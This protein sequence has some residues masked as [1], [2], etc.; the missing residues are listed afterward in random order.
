MGRS[1]IGGSLGPYL[2]IVPDWWLA[3]AAVDFKF[4][5]GQY[6]NGADGADVTTLLSISRA[7]VAY[8]QTVAGAL[9]SFATNTLRITDKGLLVEGSRENVNQRSQALAD[10]NQL[11]GTATNNQTAAPDGTTTA[12]KYADDTSNGRHLFG[13]NSL[14]GGDLANGTT[15]VLSCYVKNGT[16]R[17]CGMDFHNGTTNA[18]IVFDMQTGTITTT[19]GTLYG[20]SS[21]ETLANGWYRIAMVFTADANT[22]QNTELWAADQATPT[23]NNNG[24][25]DYI[26]NASDFYAWGLQCEVGAFASSYIPT[27]GASSVIRAADAITITGAAQTAIAAATGSIVAQTDKGGAA[28][29]AANIVDSNGTNLLGFNSSNNA[30]ASITSTLTT[31]NTANRT[32]EDKMGLAWNAGGRSLVLNNGT[33]ATDA[34]AQTPNSTQHLGSSGSVNFAYAYVERL[35]IWTSKLADATLQGFTAP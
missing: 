28:G 1:I 11:N 15:A 26:G 21:V 27:P 34:V 3:S 7:S 32:T 16:R 10:N 24:A 35:T 2:S 6:Y 33:V 14:A 9:T 5:T 12:A 25:Y 30:I 23:I 20:S 18:S 29:F 4:T 13:Y 22:G 8:A 31:G 19:S 17:Y